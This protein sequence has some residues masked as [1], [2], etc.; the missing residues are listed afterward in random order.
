MLNM[1]LLY[2]D[3]IINVTILIQSI[4]ISSN[5]IRI[6]ILLNRYMTLFSPSCVEPSL[7]FTTKRFPYF[8]ERTDSMK[9][10][11]YR[12]SSAVDFTIKN[13]TSLWVS[14]I[15]SYQ[16]L[17]RISKRRICPGK[18]NQLD[19][20]SRSVLSPCFPVQ[21]LS[22]NIWNISDARDLSD[23]GGMGDKGLFKH[24]VPSSTHWR[25]R[26]TCFDLRRWEAKVRLKMPFCWR[27]TKQAIKEFRM[28]MSCG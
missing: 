28:R 22:D 17:S 14:D 21:P 25:A 26:N 12:P 18:D 10:Y 15:H 16:W 23:K 3:L 8:F 1:L 4:Y 13:P 7:P 19:T 2:I 5:R 11:I 6:Y 9:R 20:T 24:L 27:T